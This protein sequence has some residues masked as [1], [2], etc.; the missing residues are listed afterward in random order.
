M[1]RKYES[2]ERAAP[3][4]AGYAP[5]KRE[6]HQRAHR[7]QGDANQMVRS[8]PS[9]EQ[10][11]VEHVGNPR[12]WKRV[13]RVAGGEGPRNPRKAQA[14]AHVGFTDIF[15]IIVVEEIVADR[16][17]VNEEN[18]GEQNQ[19]DPDAGSQMMR[20][21]RFTNDGFIAAVC[22]GARHPEESRLTCGAP[23]RAAFVRAP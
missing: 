5:Q 12:E 19:I 11:K 17:S 4:R 13:R 23:I 9:S 22:F 3:R 16:L 8:T 20:R 6:Q 21:W 1:E 10:L 2:D 15:R 14:A 18:S 7:V